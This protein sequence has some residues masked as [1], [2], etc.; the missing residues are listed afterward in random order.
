MA[1]KFKK[2]DVVQLLSGG[3]GMTVDAEPGDP[4]NAYSSTPKARTNYRC[5]W[6][7]GATAAHGEYAEHLLQ[8]FVPPVKK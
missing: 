5:E 1:N 8:K 3:P 6:F 4:V 7:K 2:G